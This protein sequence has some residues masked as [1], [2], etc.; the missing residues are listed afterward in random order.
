[1]QFLWDFAFAIKGHVSFFCLLY[2]CTLENWVLCSESS[3]TLVLIIASLLQSSIHRDFLKSC[4]CPHFR[5][6]YSWI[7]SLV[8]SSKYFAFL[9]LLQHDLHDLDILLFLG[10]KSHSLVTISCKYTMHTYHM[11]Y[12]LPTHPLSPHVQCSQDFP[13]PCRLALSSMMPRCWEALHKAFSIVIGD[14][15]KSLENP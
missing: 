8:C 3:W 5:L 14:K 9:Y 13:L 6:Q 1:M 10:C 12:H 11:C 2:V 4:S 7:Q 15:S